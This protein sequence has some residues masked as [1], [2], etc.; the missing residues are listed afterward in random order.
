MIIMK[1]R[2][3]CLP[4]KTAVPMTM[5]CDENHTSVMCSRC[6]HRREDCDR[7]VIE[8]SKVGTCAPPAYLQRGP[9]WMY[10]ATI[11]RHCERCPAGSAANMSYL[12]T[13]VVAVGM[14]IAISLLVLAHLQNTETR[15]RAMVQGERARANTTGPIARL[16]LNWMQATSLLITIK[17][18][19][20][21]AVQTVGVWAEYAQ[22]SVCLPSLFP[23]SNFPK[24]TYPLSSVSLSPSPTG[25]QHEKFLHPLRIAL[26]LLHDLRLRAH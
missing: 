10:F 8:S 1:A 21:D 6:Y 22:V 5:Y 13:A 9:E 3:A 26:G 25:H 7:G 11:A 12:L 23:A 16:L 24:R 18:T 2:N 15:L 17:F 14:L 4:N 19:P 20:P